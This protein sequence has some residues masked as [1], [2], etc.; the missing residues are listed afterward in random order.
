MGLAVNRGLFPVVEYQ[1]AVVGANGVLGQP[2]VAVE[3]PGVAHPVAPGPAFGRAE[4][5]VDNVADEYRAVEAELSGAAIAA[6]SDRKL[7]AG[8]IGLLG[9]TACGVI[10]VAESVGEAGGAEDGGLRLALAVSKRDVKTRPLACATP[11]AFISCKA[12]ST[13]K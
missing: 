11:C 4:G 9:K 2:A 1:A 7:G 5:L 12:L 3:L 6:V 13:C 10:A 8:G